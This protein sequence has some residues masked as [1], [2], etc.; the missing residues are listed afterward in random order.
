MKIFIIAGP[1]GAGKTTFARFFLKQMDNLAKQKIGFAFATTLS[2][3][4]YLRRIQKWKKLL[5]QIELVFLRLPSPVFAINRVRQRV[6][7][8]GH[9]I[10][11]PVIRRRFSRGLSNLESYKKVVDAWRVY[12]NSHEP[13]L[14]VEQYAIAE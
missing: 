2:S 3:A 7:Q 8:G 11:E 9:N 5:Y 4:N 13:P 12:D 10:P 6:R 14:L 1:N